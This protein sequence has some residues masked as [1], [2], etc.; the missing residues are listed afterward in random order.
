MK[1][2]AMG[3]FEAQRHRMLARIFVAGV[4]A[5]IAAV[6]VSPGSAAAFQERVL[7]SFCGSGGYLCTDGI[8]PLGG[9]LRDALGNLYGT[10]VTGGAFNGGTVF[11]LIPNAAK[12]AWTQK[13]L[14]SFCAQASCTDGFYPTAGLI[15]DASG[16]LYGTTEGGG[17]TGLNDGTVF[18]LT[19]NAAKTAWTHKVLYSFC[20][21]ADC[22]DG[23][24]PV[25]SLIMDASGNLFGTTETG[26]DGGNPY[27]GGTVFELTPDKTRTAW[28]H[29]YCTAFARNPVART[30]SIR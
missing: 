1:D 22:I 14:Y 11:E 24:L 15:R 13:I 7:Y 28:T 18:E 4:G 6:L 9:L 23:S 29:K 17:A 19:P 12:T 8:D 27:P 25:A 26:G 16:S 21:Q 10:T 2:G 30:A 5:L 3:I 20:E